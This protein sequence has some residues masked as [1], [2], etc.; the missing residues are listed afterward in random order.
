[1]PT[2]HRRVALL[3]LAVALAVS[4]AA[5]AGEA[6]P[7]FTSLFNG[8]DL[9]G[10]KV[11]DGDNGHW[12]VVDGVIDYDAESAGA[13]RGQEP[14]DRGRVRRLRPEASSGVSRT[15]PTSTRTCPIIRYDGTHKKGPDGKEIKLAVPDSDSGIFLRGLVEVAGEHLVLAHRLRRGVRLPHG[16]EDADRGA[17]RR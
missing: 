14:L 2:Y 3:S 11:P 13:R 15:R 10:W 1:M 6:P 16:R 8:K 17:R 5:G 9:T 4:G 12:K 7:G